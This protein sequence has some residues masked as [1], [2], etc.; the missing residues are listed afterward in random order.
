V[1]TG[2]PPERFLPGRTA[3]KIFDGSAGHHD[4]EHGGQIR[5]WRGA[6]GL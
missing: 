6:R 5:A 3:W 1:A 4:R 2:V